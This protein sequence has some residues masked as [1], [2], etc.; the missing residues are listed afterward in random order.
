MEECANRFTGQYRRDNS[1]SK[2]IGDNS[3]DAA[4]SQL[5]C[6][7]ELGEH[8]ATRDSVMRQ[9]THRLDGWR[10]AW[11]F[12]NE[13]GRRIDAWIGRIESLDVGEDE[14]EIGLHQVGYH[15]R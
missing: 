10:N 5:L 15:R 8:P 2:P 11:N 12:C 6:R 13:L 9:A 7:L 1:W 4:R 3:W 14:Q